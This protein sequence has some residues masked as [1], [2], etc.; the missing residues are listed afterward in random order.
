MMKQLI[1]TIHRLGP[2]DTASLCDILEISGKRD[3]H[4]R[5]AEAL[6]SH[7]GMNRVL[8]TLDPDEYR[9]L[10]HIY[11]NPKGVTYGELESRLKIPVTRIEEIS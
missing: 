3:L 1:E 11:M 4:T 10:V 5:I 9:V 2:E 7:T 8:S 6:T